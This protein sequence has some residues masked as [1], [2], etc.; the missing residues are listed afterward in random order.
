MLS[1]L[2]LQLMSHPPDR[3]LSTPPLSPHSTATRHQQRHQQP[4]RKLPDTAYAESVDVALLA[5]RVDRRQLRQVAAP[6][7]PVQRERLAG[8]GEVAA[9]HDE[10][11]GGVVL[12]TASDEAAHHSADA[13]L[14]VRSSIAGIAPMRTDSATFGARGHERA[15]KE[16]LSWA[17]ALHIALQPQVSQPSFHCSVFIANFSPAHSLSIPLLLCTSSCATRWFRSTL[18]QRRRRCSLRWANT[19]RAPTSRRGTRCYATASCARLVL[20]VPIS[21]GSFLAMQVS[22]LIVL[23]SVSLLCFIFSLISLAIAFF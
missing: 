2:A 18:L 8:A 19:Q 7:G 1:S 13:V 6:C 4:S 14:D 9:M 12:C 15:A 22:T 11:T 23:F 3:S 10:R 21:A 5:P 16:A 20:L 17:T